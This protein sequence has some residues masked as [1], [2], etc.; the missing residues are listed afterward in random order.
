MS[1]YLLRHACDELRHFPQLTGLYAM[2][3]RLPPHAL[4]EAGA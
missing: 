3:R 4:S 2:I 1:Y